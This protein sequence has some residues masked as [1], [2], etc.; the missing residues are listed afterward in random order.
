MSL[1][2]HVQAAGLSNFAWGHQC[3]RQDTIQGLAI[4]YGVTTMAIRMTNNL[5]SDQGLQSRPIIY[6]P[7]WHAFA[8]PNSPA[9]QS[10]VSAA[11]A[12][13]PSAFITCMIVNI[14]LPEAV[15]IAA[16]VR[17]L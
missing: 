17:H 4:K 13:L 8:G 3:S 14:C 7:G 5:I 6:V 16:W 11:C 9:Q 2:L 1:C 12:I 15:T 10:V